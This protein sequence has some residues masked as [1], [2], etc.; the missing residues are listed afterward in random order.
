MGLR[1]SFSEPFSHLLERSAFLVE[2]K[3]MADTYRLA[4]L[5]GYRPIH[6]S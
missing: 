3:F 6:S 2:F 5:T 1:D 4:W